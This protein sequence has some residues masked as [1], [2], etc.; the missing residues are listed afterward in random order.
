M[1]WNEY[2]L[3]AS[4]PWKMAYNMMMNRQ[5]QDTTAHQLLHSCRKCYFPSMLSAAQHP[6]RE[7][8]TT[9]ISITVILVWNNSARLPPKIL[10][11]LALTH[12]LLNQRYTP[13]I[14]AAATATM[15]LETT[16]ICCPRKTANHDTSV[17]VQTCPQAF[18]VFTAH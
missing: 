17:K 18:R 12:A 13:D 3:L 9:R 8:H 15:Q 14:P 4:G 5:S 16:K 7:R 6:P 11:R 10:L 2:G 1:G